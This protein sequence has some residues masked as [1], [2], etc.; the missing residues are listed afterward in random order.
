MGYR[1]GSRKPRCALCREWAVGS[2]LRCEC[3]LCAAHLPAESILCSAC[4][5]EYRAASRPRTRS[6]SLLV[7]LLVVAVAVL[8]SLLLV[9][10]RALPIAWLDRWLLLVLWASG[11]I[12]Y[13]AVAKPHAH[14][15]RALT[16]RWRQRFVVA[17]PSRR[18]LRGGSGSDARASD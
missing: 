15:F 14:V 2:C 9:V 18:H 8:S 17:T 4:E 5:V 13:A 12:A 16:D 7:A 10:A 11:L 1:D 3:P 6:V